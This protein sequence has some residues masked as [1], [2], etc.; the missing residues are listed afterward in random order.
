MRGQQYLTP[1]EEKALIVHGWRRCGHVEEP[2]HMPKICEVGPAL[3]KTP[4]ALGG[5]PLIIVSLPRAI[6]RAARPNSSD[7]C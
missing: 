4:L 1:S 5:S 6:P 7:P 3:K 2:M